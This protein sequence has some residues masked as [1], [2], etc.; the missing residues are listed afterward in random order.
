MK[1][2]ENREGEMTIQPST[3]NLEE[4]KIAALDKMEL[5]YI[6]FTSIASFHYFKLQAKGNIQLSLAA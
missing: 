6:S 5:C 2:I 3:S 4:K 1:K